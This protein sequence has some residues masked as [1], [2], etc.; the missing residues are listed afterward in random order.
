M[1]DVVKKNILTDDELV[2]AAGGKHNLKI[3]ATKRIY[4]EKCGRMTD[5]II[6]MGTNAACSECGNKIESVTT[7]AK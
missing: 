2:E 1:S 4:C 7:A 5:F 6:F 3:G